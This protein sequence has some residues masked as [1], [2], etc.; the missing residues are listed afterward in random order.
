MTSATGSFTVPLTPSEAFVLFTPRGE[1]AWAE[2]WDPRFP[3][4]VDDDTT[5][6]TVFT[7][8]AGGRRTTWVVTG[9]TAGQAISYAR[10]AHGATAGTVAVTLR[11]ST[12]GTEVTVT[13][14]LTA[15]T[16]EAE[17]AARDFFDGYAAY[18]ESWRVAIDAHL[19]YS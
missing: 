12:G 7:T 16:A 8:D 6:G 15:L 4:P 1:R 11:P 14:D 13:Y 19:T 17:P 5:P 2:G 18:L 10:V 9:R 3:A